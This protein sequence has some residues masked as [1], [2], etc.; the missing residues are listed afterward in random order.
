MLNIC[1][2]IDSLNGMVIHR[3][4]PWFSTKLINRC[5]CGMFWFHISFKNLL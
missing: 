3:H 5:N 2:I 1:F 4:E